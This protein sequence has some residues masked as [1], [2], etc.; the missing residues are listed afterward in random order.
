MCS[1]LC[2]IKYTSG[3][4]K[5]I[6]NTENNSYLTIGIKMRQGKIKV[7]IKMYL[8]FP[9]INLKRD[10]YNVFKVEDKHLP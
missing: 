6:W 3:L 7:K 10:V 5:H 4:Q 1:V 2:S 9:R 8:K